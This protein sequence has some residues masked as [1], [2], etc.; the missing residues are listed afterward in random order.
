M[1]FIYNLVVSCC[2]CCCHI[3]RV[4]LCA[5]HRWQPTRLLRPWD[6]PGKKTGVVCHFLLQCMKVKSE[7]EVAQS[8][9]TLHNPWTAAYQAPLSMGFSRQEYWSGLPFPSPGDF[10]D[11]GIEAG[12]PALQADS[13]PSEPPGKLMPLTTWLCSVDANCFKFLFMSNLLGEY[14]SAPLRSSLASMQTDSLVKTPP[15]S[16]LKNFT[17]S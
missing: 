12:S 1:P 15:A 14:K 11:L 13:L 7:S 6:S 4:R 8:C 16:Y 17:Y 3:S 10:P 9:L 5:T 2:C